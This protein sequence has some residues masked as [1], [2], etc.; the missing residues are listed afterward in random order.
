VSKERPLSQHANSISLP[1]LDHT[2]YNK[3]TMTRALIARNHSR[4]YVHAVVHA[5]L[6]LAFGFGVDEF[7]Y[8]ASG[9]SI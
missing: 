9:G 5:N 6:V 1:R 2:V 8:S 3:V 7:P 4:R